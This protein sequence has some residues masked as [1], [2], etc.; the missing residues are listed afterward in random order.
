[1]VILGVGLHD[2]AFSMSLPCSILDIRDLLHAFDTVGW[3]PRDKLLI[4]D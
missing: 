3:F 2:V 4:E 1:M